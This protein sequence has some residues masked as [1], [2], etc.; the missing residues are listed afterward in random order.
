[1]NVLRYFCPLWERF[2]VRKNKQKIKIDPL[3]CGIEGGFM[4]RNIKK[5]LKEICRWGRL[6]LFLE[7][8]TDEG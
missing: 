8:E 2:Y 1:M 7:I 6:D 5:W 4:E 3:T